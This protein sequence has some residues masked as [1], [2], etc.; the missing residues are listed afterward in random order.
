M[1]RRITIAA[2]VLAVA[3]CVAGAEVFVGPQ[4]PQRGLEIVMNGEFEQG[5][6]AW[7]A[8]W[9][10]LPG[11]FRLH[12]VQREAGEHSLFLGLRDG[13]DG[14]V[15]QVV[16][17]PAHRALSLRVLAT[18]HTSTEAAVV[19]T[20]TRVADGVVLAEV[21]VDGI[22][23]GVLA[24]GFDSGPGGSA[25]LMLR[26][27]GEKG[28]EAL[29]DSV[30]IAKPVQACDAR[31][32]DYAGADLVLAQGQG[33]RV[34]ADFEPRLLPQAAQMLQET[35]EDVTG[36]RTTSIGAG[37]SVSVSQPEATGWPERESYRLKVC[38]TGVTITAP[39]EEGA[40]HAVMTLIDL[41]RAEPG[42]GARILAVDV[43]D[44]PALPWRIASAADFSDPANAAR[45]LA[46]LKLNMALVDYEDEVGPAIIDELR[47]VGV[48]PVIRVSA[49]QTDGVG[50]AM[51][52][53]VERLGARY[54]LVSP[55]STPAAEDGAVRPHHWD[56]PP[57]A[58]VAAFAREHA[59]EV[60][61]VVPA[62]RAVTTP[63]HSVVEFNISSVVLVTPDGWPREVV[64][65]LPARPGG[66]DGE[67]LESWHDAGVRYV[68]TDWTFLQPET[69]AQALGER[70]AGA[71]CLGVEVGL[72][73][74][75]G[76]EQLAEQMADL[77]WRGMPS[78]E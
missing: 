71:A 75:R 60:T 26:V 10:P 17:L 33:L 42:G 27:V 2:V 34:D 63:L 69:V 11:A 73:G 78:E 68:L 40:F 37:V 54:V 25:E 39:A 19:A 29:I 41:L 6:M 32:P 22:E 56:E 59:G 50:A 55:P 74:V 62:S 3:S 48:E 43:Q 72:D 51:R 18:C 14:G 1:L 24:E 67:Y 12:R 57:L 31:P 38:E 65:V 66:M 64:A 61:V 21:V 4:A 46:R 16:N 47:S 8:G 7:A 49:G 45:T 35:L 58:Q 52:D 28:S 5:G 44:K 23:R 77:A 9:R 13:G 15:M 53:A 36:A 70:A 76:A 20:L 30:A